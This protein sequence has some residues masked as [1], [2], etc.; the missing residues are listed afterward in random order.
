MKGI[1]LLTSIICGAM[2]IFTA[3]AAHAIVA[4]D[5][6]LS[7]LVDVS[8]SVDSTEFDLQK[9]GY[10][11]AFRSTNVHNAIAGNTIGKIAVNMIYWSSTSNQVE[12]VTWTEIGNAAQANAFA[13]AI[14]ATSRPFF[15]TTFLGSAISF[16]TPG[17]ASNDFDGTR[18][19]IDISGDGS[20]S[21]GDTLAAAKT[22]AFNA[23]IDTINGIAIGNDTLFNFYQNSVIGGTDAFAIQATDFSSFQTAIEEKLLLEITDPDPDPQPDPD[24]DPQPD[25]DPNPTA[26]PEPATML[27]L[28]SGLGGAAFFRRKQ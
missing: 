19:V 6:E 4:V 25:P 8:S 15:G 23:G 12:A 14:A 20:S 16:A 17:F 2:I 24:P 7:L 11:N 26:I 22:A 21:A 1:K 18:Q 10:V 27:L 9:T 13:D 3:P 5:I 28:A